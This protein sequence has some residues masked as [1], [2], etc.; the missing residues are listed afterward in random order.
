MKGYTVFNVD[1]IEGLP[2]KY[3]ALAKAPEI[4]PQERIAVLEEFF[5][6]TKD[7]GRD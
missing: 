4:S 1:Q 7:Q 3:Y 6:N 2:E 5:A